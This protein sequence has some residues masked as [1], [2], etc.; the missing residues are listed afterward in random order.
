MPIQVV[1]PGCK[2]RFTVSDQFAGRT[3]PCPKCKKPLSI[4]KPAVQ[5]V[6]I[7]EPEAPVASS[8]GT[9]RMPTAPIAR[10]DRPVSNLRIAISIAGFVA[11]VVAAIAVRF[12][13]GPG[14][15]PT[16][17]LAT[18]G[19][20]LALPCTIVGYDIVRNRDLDPYRGRGLLLRGLICAVVYAALWGVRGMLPPDMTTEMWPWLYI[21]PIFFGAGSLAALASFDLDWGTGVAHYSL[22]VLIT[23]LLRWV[24]GFPPV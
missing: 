16:W 22:Y 9:G 4:P 23:A 7:H 24:A 14:Q 15:A 1:C 18:S 10:R 2:S 11:A 8:T 5:A 19:F 12:V 17:L 21:A 13:F 20:L 3:G 6:T